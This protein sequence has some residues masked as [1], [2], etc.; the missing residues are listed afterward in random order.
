MIDKAEPPGRFLAAR[1]LFLL[2]RFVPPPDLHLRFRLVWKIMSMFL[3]GFCRFTGDA[4]VFDCVAVVGATGAV[5]TIIRELLEARKFPFKKMKFVAS[6]DRPAGEIP[7]AGQEI[8]VEE[9]QGPG[10]RR[11]GSGH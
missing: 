10:F 5:G 6:A 11:R 4:S 3:V 1:G 8:V 7:F 9:L 2:P